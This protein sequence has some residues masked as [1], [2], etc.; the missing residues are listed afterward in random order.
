MH[1]VPSG[2][3]ERVRAAA[4]RVV[5]RI[6]A[7][8]RTATRPAPVLIGLMNDLA[9]S[10]K[11]LLAENAFLRQQLSVAA[12]KTKRPRVAAHERGL[13]VLLARLIP[14]WWDAVHVIKPD[15][16]LRWHREGFRLFWRY[17]SKSTS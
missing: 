12:R 15:T 14:Q 13:L 8:A 1:R 9:R 7:F 16:I 11:Q 2:L 17:K 5:R 4:T 6:E 10:G 3:I